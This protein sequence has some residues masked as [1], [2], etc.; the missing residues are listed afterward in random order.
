MCPLLAGGAAMPAALRFVEE[1]ALV[2]KFAL[3]DFGCPFP[4]L[5]E[6]G[7]IVVV[8]HRGGPS[9]GLFRVV[10]RD[11]ALRSTLLGKGPVRLCQCTQAVFSRGPVAFDAEVR[12]L[13]WVNAITHWCHQRLIQLA[14]LDRCWDAHHLGGVRC[15]FHN[16][17]VTTLRLSRE[18]T[19]PLAFRND[20]LHL[21][22]DQLS[23]DVRVDVTHHLLRNIE[24][25]P[26]STCLEEAVGSFIFLSL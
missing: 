14:V 7:D 15:S 12:K 2:L 1:D 23:C 25:H 18:G 9:L 6:F 24:F 26:E 16:Q 10:G 3:C 17:L 11:G 13:N 20:Y 5:R 8:I 19:G 22:C 21:V 4:A